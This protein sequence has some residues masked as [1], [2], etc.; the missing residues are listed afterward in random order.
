METKNK[1]RLK[2]GIGIAV[3]IILAWG[4]YSYIKSG[5]KIKTAKAVAGQIAPSVSV[6]GEIN[7]QQADLSPKIIERIS[8]I[9]VKEGD[10]VFAGQL[11]AKLGNYESA[12]REYD[13][14]RSL[15]NSGFATKQQMDNSRLQYENSCFISPIGGIVSLVANKIGESVSPGMTSFSVVN[16]ASTYAEVQIDES[17]IGDATRGKEV[18]IYADAYPDTA[19]EGTLVNIGQEA[20]LKKIGGRIKMDEEDKIFRG[21]VAFKNPGYKLKIGMTI[22]ADI[23]IEKKSGVL[24]IPREAIVNKEGKTAVYL[25]KKGR[26]KEL[27]IVTGLKDTA[28]VEIKSGLKDGDEVAVSNLD[29]IKNNAK[30]IIEK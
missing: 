11:L 24:I 20:E 5:T 28:N 15:F 7:G 22:N 9:G 21:R 30:V 8:W 6:S 12:K 4:S 1:N 10:R 23:I 14:T 18:F 19:F 26:V 3:A 27:Q 2:W 13:S 17:D 16:P 25:V 29:K